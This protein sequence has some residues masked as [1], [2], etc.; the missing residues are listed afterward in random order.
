MSAFGIAVNNISIVDKGLVIIDIKNITGS[1]STSYTDWA[2]RTLYY[3]LYPNTNTL[4]HTIAIS[5]TTVAWTAVTISGGFFTD[6]PNSTLVVY[7]R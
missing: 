4:G 7:A 2:G 1:G 5:G 6:A 3:S